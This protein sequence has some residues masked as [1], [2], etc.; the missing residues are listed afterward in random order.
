MYFLKEIHTCAGVLLAKTF[1]L[2]T[3]FVKVTFKVRN[4]EKQARILSL[5]SAFKKLT[6]QISAT[7]A[8]SVSLS[9]QYFFCHVYSWGHLSCR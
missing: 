5:F 1:P 7:T 4:S 3:F 2:N 6:L 8:L 9:F